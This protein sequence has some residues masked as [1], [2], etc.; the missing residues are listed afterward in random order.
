MGKTALI[1]KEDNKDGAHLY[2]EMH[3]THGPHLLLVHGLMS[4]RA[5]WL[6]NLRSL[7][8]FCR[9]IIVELFGHGRSPSPQNPVTY[10]PENY[11]REFE[12]IRQREGIEKWFICGQ[13]LG[14]SLTLRYSFLYPERIKAQIFTNSLSALSEA[15]EVDNP[16]GLVKL[17]LQGGRE[18]LAQLPINP[19]RSR[20]LNPDVKKALVD[21]IKLINMEGFAR[22]MLYLTPRCSVRNLIKDITVPTLLI[23]GRFDKRFSPMIAQFREDMSSLNVIEL[24]GGHA[25]NVDAADRFNESVREFILHR[26]SN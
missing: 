6:L 21:D 4:S 16:E 8:E 7:T 5:Q 15:R 25:V 14:A 22:T 11:V 24:A 10:Y 13:S 19:T 2:Y 12:R 9:P 1:V 3:G 26:L 17:L 18:T 23:A 20:F